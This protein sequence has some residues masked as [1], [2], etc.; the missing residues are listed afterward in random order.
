MGIILFTWSGIPR[1]GIYELA[2]VNFCF[3]DVWKDR[4]PNCP[5]QRVGLGV[6][7]LGLWKHNSRW[8]QRD[9]VENSGTFS[10][11]IWLCVRNV[12]SEKNEYVILCYSLSK[13]R[14]RKWAKYYL[15]GAASPEVTTMSWPL[16]T[17][18]SRTS[19]RIEIQILHDIEYTILC[20]S[21]LVKLL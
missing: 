8:R 5:W 16:L 13:L 15:P 21:I 4:N 10:T 14:L 3:H 7:V 20:D 19:E 11:I 9:S 2:T 18:A 6:N 17:V 12:S 1:S